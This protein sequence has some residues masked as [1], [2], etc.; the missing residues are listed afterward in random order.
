MT[1]LEKIKV[2]EK[3]VESCFVRGSCFG[4]PFYQAPVHGRPGRCMG[5]KNAGKLLLAYLEDI[6][7][8]IKD[9]GEKKIGA[10]AV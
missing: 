8:E 7:K 9:G 2:A 3:A 4:C 10:R 6:R 1:N 5:M